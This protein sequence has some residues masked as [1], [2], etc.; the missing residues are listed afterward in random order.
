MREIDLD[1]NA[2]DLKSIDVNLKSL[3]Y[4][5]I[6]AETKSITKAAQELYITQSTLSKSIILLEQHLEVQLLVRSGR[7]LALTEAGEY[8]YGKW[9]ELIKTYKDQLAGVR[10]CREVV[11]EKI[12]IGY[13]PALDVVDYFDRYISRIQSRWPQMFIEIFRMNNTRLFEHLNAEKVDLLFTLERDIP[14]KRELYEWK[15]VSKVPMAALISAE[16][17]LSEKETLQAEDFEG[18]RVL[19]NNPGGALSREEWVKDFLEEKRLNPKEIIWVNND[20]TAAVNAMGGQGIAIGPLCAFGKLPSRVK[21]CVVK[22]VFFEIA[23][24]WSAKE[25]AGQ[26]ALIHEILE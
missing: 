2:I 13:F 25:S 5:V 22:D 12:R 7:K 20:L 1:F 11:P 6:V 10:R 16:N 15:V 26:K 18:Q 8:L 14:A 19:V 24:L 4:F 23:A 21:M 3:Y 9:K 17:P